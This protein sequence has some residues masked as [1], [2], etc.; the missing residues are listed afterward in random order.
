MPQLIKIGSRDSQ[1]ALLQSQMVK[2][3]LE[4]IYPD[5]Q[6]EIIKI[7]TQGDKILDVALS[8]IGDKGLFVKELE[9]ELL[10]ASVD[11]AVHSMKDMPTKLPDG[12][13]IS[14]IL[15]REDVRDVICLSQNH[16]EYASVKALNQESLNNDNDLISQLV[17]KLNIVA[18]SSLRRIA[19][20]KSYYPKL[21]FIDIRGNLNTRF[22]KLDDPNNA[23]DGIVLAAA[24]I[25][26]L[27]TVD[28][29]FSHRI[30]AFLNPREIMPAVAQGALAIEFLE[31]RK[32][33]EKLI[34]PLVNPK[35]E[36]ILQI[37]RNFLNELEGGCQV[38]IGIYSELENKKTCFHFSV[39][40]LDGT[41]TIKDRL[42]IFDSELTP[43]LGRLLAQRLIKSGATALLR[44]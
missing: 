3:R 39:S 31:S 2:A 24:G 23:M 36:M 10:E 42:S 16:P 18:T 40:S 13:K 38:P 9:H 33:I 32:D 26:R 1:L 4:E 8:K 11:I 27:M 17:E 29:S 41:K 19:L 6:C 28:D 43:Q 44:G 37:E 35:Q 20:L 34:E 15:E 7:K 25:K 5:I 30:S 12:L 21:N 22:R 14:S